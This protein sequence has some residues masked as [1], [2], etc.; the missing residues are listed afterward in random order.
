MAKS[1]R[2]T[3][4]RKERDAAKSAKPKAP[5]K[6]KTLDELLKPENPYEQAVADHIRGRHDA[7]LEAA[8]VEHQR[9]IADCLAY[10]ADVARGRSGATQCVMMTDEEVFGLAAH[11]FLD[12]NT[13][14]GVKPG[15]A[16]RVG[17][18]AEAAPAK[19]AKKTEKAKAKKA[20][21]AE[22]AKAKKKTE[23]KDDGQM[24]FD[25]GL[26]AEPAEK[27]AETEVAE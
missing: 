5:E 26:E 19:K 1:K 24:F 8:I 17:A 18:P 15:A 25:F 4:A 11:Y 21:K 27:P 3:E 22:K 2:K 6:P 23:K 13:P 12:G 10:V 20:K 14:A 7:A 16:V 9:S